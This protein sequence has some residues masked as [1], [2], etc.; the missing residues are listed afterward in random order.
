M[1]DLNL[2]QSK[3]HSQDTENIYKKNSHFL[4]TQYKNE[5]K[6]HKY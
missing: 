6:E 3:S 1:N 2:F 5:W 4:F